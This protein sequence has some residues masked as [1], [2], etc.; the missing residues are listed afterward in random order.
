MSRTPLPNRRPALTVSTG[1]VSIDHGGI[2]H[3]MLTIGYDAAGEPREVFCSDFKVGTEMNTL[4]GDACVM[5]SILLQHGAD[6]H[7]IAAGLAEPKSII[8]TIAA[9]VAAAPRY[10]GN[11]HGFEPHP[12]P[13]DT[14]PMPPAGSLM[15]L[16]NVETI[17]IANA[18]TQ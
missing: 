16:T 8:G 2:K 6:L 3:L 15:A 17:A 9:A 14:P 18:P 7:D 13:P 11:T 10:R 5:L 1:H 4:V 12:T